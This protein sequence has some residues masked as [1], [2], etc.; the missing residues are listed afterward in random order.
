MQNTERSPFTMRHPLEQAAI[1]RIT[2]ARETLTYNL[3]IQEVIDQLKSC[4]KPNIPLTR[5]RFV[6]TKVFETRQFSS[7]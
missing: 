7:L 5:V 6:Q 1:I 4:F 3:L 2:K